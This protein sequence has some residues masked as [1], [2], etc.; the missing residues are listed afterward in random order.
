MNVY[1]IEIPYKP[2]SNFE[3][4]KYAGDLGL[5]VRGV[6]MRDCLPPTPLEVEMGVTNMNVSGQGVIK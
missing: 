4:I 6:Y 2:L 1:G 5:D 3:L